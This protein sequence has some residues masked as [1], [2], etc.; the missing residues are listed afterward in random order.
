MSELPEPP[1]DPLELTPVEEFK[2]DRRSRVWS[3][4]DE[5]GRRWVVKHFLHSPHRQRLTAAL[6]CHPA[7]R[8]AKWHGRLERNGV[9]VVPVAEA[10]VGEHG[11]HWLISP[12]A[13]PS[14]YNW[15][16][17]CVPAASV[18]KRHDYTR[19]LGKI[20]GQLLA[21]RLLHRDFKSSNVVIGDDGVLRLID[22]GGVRSAREL[23]LLARALM[24]LTRLHD[25]FVDAASYHATPD[26][27]RPTR[28]DRLRFYR[29]MATT[30]K[31][32]PDGLARLLR[33]KE[34]DAPSDAA[35]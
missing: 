18:V 3:V 4:R 30:W 25:T 21:G 20:A 32:A 2:R 35:D 19:Q 9:P 22:A 8:E 34:F 7:Q 10:G 17:H 6:N 31:K 5:A 13:G 12:Y 23:P 15:L 11:R 16:R 1:E 14:L 24:M 29:A 33:S 28:V 27:V 26:A